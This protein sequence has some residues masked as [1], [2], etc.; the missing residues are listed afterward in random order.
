LLPSGQLFKVLTAEAIDTKI[1]TVSLAARLF[2]G[3]KNATFGPTTI[4]RRMLQDRA[5]AGGKMGNQINQNEVYVFQIGKV[6][7]THRGPIF[8][9]ASWTSRDNSPLS[10]WIAYGFEITVR[11]VTK[12][13]LPGFAKEAKVL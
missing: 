5:E 8:L 3:S 13:I 4:N 12:R 11:L 2:Y 7:G 1:D 9:G 6:I 10:E